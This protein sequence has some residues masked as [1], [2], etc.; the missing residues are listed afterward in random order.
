[1]KTV[2]Q[3]TIKRESHLRAL[4][5]PITVIW[6]HEYD[7]QRILDPEFPKAV[8]AMFFYESLSP[9]GA[10]YGGSTNV[11]KLHHIVGPGEELRY[12][13]VCRLDCEFCRF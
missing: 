4:G 7:E 12:L 13:H 11:T 1:M 9:R 5:H 8:D 3:E 6:E 2:Y 10:F